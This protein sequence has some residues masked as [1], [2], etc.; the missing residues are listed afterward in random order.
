MKF[1]IKD[2]FSKCDQI[3]SFLWIWSHLRKKSLMKNFHFFCKA[4]SVKVNKNIVTKWLNMYNSLT[5]RRIQ[6]SRKYIRR[7]ALLLAANYYC[8][9]LLLRCLRETWKRLCKL[10]LR[11]TVTKKFRLSFLFLYIRKLLP[12]QF[13]KKKKK[14]RS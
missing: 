7:R 1:F 14:K 2:F 4:A 3:R 10:I 13:L 9:A 5:Q 6:D 12:A 11:P 8:K